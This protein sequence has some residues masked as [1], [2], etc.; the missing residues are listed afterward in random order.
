M[1]DLTIQILRDLIKIDTRTK[2][3]N[4]IEA[5]KYLKQRC[6]E[7][8]IDSKIIE[9]SNGKGNLIAYHNYK[10][11]SSSNLLLLSHVDTSEFGDIFKWK[12][13]PLSGAEK[14]GLIIGRGAIDCKSLA[15][16]WLSILIYLKKKSW[17]WT[18]KI[19]V[20]QAIRSGKR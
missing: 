2:L 13:P 4:E 14:N 17:R 10:A 12:Y 15:S 8:G 19:K 5:I 16:L 1:I 3:N 11:D 7:Y 20:A 9:P 6:N 18:R